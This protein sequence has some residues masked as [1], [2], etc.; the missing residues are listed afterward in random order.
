MTINSEGSLIHLILKMTLNKID[1]FDLKN[2]AV[3]EWL[4]IHQM[5]SFGNPDWMTAQ[6]RYV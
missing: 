5:L 3:F 4:L 6:G 2:F 1:L